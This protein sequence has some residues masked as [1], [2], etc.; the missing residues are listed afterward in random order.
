MRNFF[1]I[2]ILTTSLYS[3]TAQTKFGV[4]LSGGIN[5]LSVS[6]D[7][8]NLT[9]FS[10]SDL[11]FQVGF[12]IEIPLEHSIVFAPELL[13]ATK[14]DYFSY[15]DY[16][17]SFYSEINLS[18][19]QLPMMTRIMIIDYFGLEFGPYAAVLF[20]AT[21]KDKIEEY[22]S[23]TT[24]DGSIKSELKDMD[25]GF[26][27]GAIYTSQTGLFVNMRLSLGIKDIYE[28]SNATMKNK[29]ISM[30]MGYIFK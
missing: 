18:Y 26:N 23:I 7:L 5:T 2:L 12:L 8:E 16:N 22:G 6:G 13:F 28:A 24:F 3:T 20:D 4:K 29:T 15:D 1:I 10:R 9:D 17:Y 27:V 21:E 11:G 19:L 30:G 25:Y 14:G